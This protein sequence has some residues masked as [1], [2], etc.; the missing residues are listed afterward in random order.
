MRSHAR[1]NSK[2]VR[3]EAVNGARDV[4]ADVAGGTGAATAGCGCGV[5]GASVGG[6]SAGAAVGSLA[7]GGSAASAVASTGTW[8]VLNTVSFP[9]T[10]KMPPPTRPADCFSS[11]TCFAS[12]NEV[13]LGLWPVA[14]LDGVGFESGGVASSTRELMGFKRS[15][16]FV[17][18]V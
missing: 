15:F 5:G 2:S 6:S 13:G 10:R 11:R 16:L 9:D 18:S 3:G 14:T 8:R 12:L 7:R 1:V 17:G 4:A